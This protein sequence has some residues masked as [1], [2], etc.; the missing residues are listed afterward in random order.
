[1]AYEP[2]TWKT[3][4]VVTS[5]KL[6]KLE[7]GVT[8]AGGLVVTMTVTFGETDPER[9]VLD[10]TAGEIISA[11]PVVFVVDSAE[12]IAQLLKSYSEHDGKYYFPVEVGSD[13]EQELVAD[14]LTDYPSWTASEG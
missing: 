1:M 13:F 3:G 5:A 7:Q 4:D 14:A 8:A 10:K 11:W 9:A 2:T 12:H 6:N